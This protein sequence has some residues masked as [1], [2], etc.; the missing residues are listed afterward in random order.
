MSVKGPT[1]PATGSV[2]QFLDGSA[3]GIVPEGLS[4]CFRKILQYPSE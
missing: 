2:A 4:G 1:L 3:A